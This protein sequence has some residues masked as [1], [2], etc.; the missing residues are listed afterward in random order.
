MNV[1]INVLKDGT[2]TDLDGFVVRIE[3]AAE[4]YAVMKGIEKNDFIRSDQTSERKHYN[5]FH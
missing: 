3:D 5:N 4:A 2:V 1:L